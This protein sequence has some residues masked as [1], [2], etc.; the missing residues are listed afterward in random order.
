MNDETMPS[1]P[2][3]RMMFGPSSVKKTRSHAQQV[4]EGEPGSTVEHDRLALGR[5]DEH[6]VEHRLE[7]VDL[8]GGRREQPADQDE[9][10]AEEA[11]AGAEGE[12]S[13]RGAPRPLQVGDEVD[14][15]PE[16]VRSS[17]RRRC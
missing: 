2:V 6:R 9:I 11:V 14:Q 12:V 4:V 8:L 13:R 16:A 3:S 1:R 10:R 5:G 7:L 15:R 17:P